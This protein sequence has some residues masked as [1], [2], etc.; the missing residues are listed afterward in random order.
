MVKQLVSRP[1]PLPSH[2][3]IVRVS[4]PI[5]I[6]P[7]T[8]MNFVAMFQ[9]DPM[10]RVLLIRQ[11]V[12]AKTV[13]VMAQRMAVPKERL[14]S[15]LGL[16]RATIDRKVRENKPL[17]SD[18]GSRV[19]GMARLVGQVQAMVD[20]SGN[21]ENFN[22]AQWVAQWLDRPL[23]AL[24]GQCPGEL[25]DTPDGQVLVSNLVA[26]MQSGAYA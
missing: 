15:T 13:D 6:P 12:S 17:S 18:E 21:P 1:L 24:A 7:A 26:R 9:T 16:A 2:P 3:I 20:E 25:M 11:G 19:L 4:A 22:A 10:E 23:P 5:E 8:A 14:I